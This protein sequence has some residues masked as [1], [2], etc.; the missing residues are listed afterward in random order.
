MIIRSFRMGKG[1][2]EHSAPFV[3]GLS[4]EELIEIIN[5]NQTYGGATISRAKSAL[6]LID[7]N[8]T[9][10]GHLLIN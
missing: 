8:F 7:P 3:R 6:S 9:R 2:K 4:E 1:I 5:S 10:T